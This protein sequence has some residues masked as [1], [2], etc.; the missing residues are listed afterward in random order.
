MRH[1]KATLGHGKATL[2]HGKADRLP[3]RAIRSYN[4]LVLN[5]LDALLRTDGTVWIELPVCH[6]SARK[7][8]V[9][10]SYNRQDGTASIRFLNRVNA[11]I[12]PRAD[13]CFDGC[14]SQLLVFRIG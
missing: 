2:G 13:K 14:Q 9:T 7:D 3:D 11:G 8:L 4:L 5:L 1:G 10:E 6:R 12:K